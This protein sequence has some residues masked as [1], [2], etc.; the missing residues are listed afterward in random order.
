[1]NSSDGS[2]DLGETARALWFCWADISGLPLFLKFRFSAPN[3]GWRNLRAEQA[4]FA[5][6]APVPFRVL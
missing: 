5:T 2:V 3:A 1:M 4:T 6:L